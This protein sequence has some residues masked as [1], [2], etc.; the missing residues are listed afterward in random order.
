[1]RKSA[2]LARPGRCVRRRVGFQVAHGALPSNGDS[3]KFTPAHTPFRNFNR[4]YGAS[5]CSAGMCRGIL[6][7]VA[8]AAAW[9]V[10]WG[11]TTPPAWPPHGGVSSRATSPPSWLPAMA[12]ADRLR[13]VAAP[14]QQRGRAAALRCSVDDLL[15]QES[16]AAMAGFQRWTAYYRV[17]NITD[18]FE[19]LCKTMLHPSPV[20]FR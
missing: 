4:S 16:A 11:F 12:S 6:G 9:P 3:Q 20:D 14:K 18:D 10:V 1:M 8:V 5:L 19:T 7:L 17:Q 15:A 2:P 13:G